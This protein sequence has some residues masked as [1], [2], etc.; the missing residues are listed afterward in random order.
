MQVTNPFNIRSEAERYNKYRPMYHAIPFQMVRD[1]LGH[2]FNAA[3]DVACGTGHSTLA[4]AKFS[5]STVGCDVSESM[6]AEAPQAPDI[7]FVQ[8]KAEE[9]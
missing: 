9:F 4:L 8:A 2:D 1:F 7:E 5:K 6:L 3:L